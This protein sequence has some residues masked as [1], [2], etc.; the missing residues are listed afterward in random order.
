MEIDIV[1]AGI[2]AQPENLPKMP[3]ERFRNF[4]LLFAMKEVVQLPVNRIL[5]DGLHLRCDG[6][7]QRL[8]HVTIETGYREKPGIA[9]ELELGDRLRVFS[10]VGGNGSVFV[11]LEGDILVLPPRSIDDAS[12]ALSELSGDLHAL[13]IRTAKPLLGEG[14][15]EGRLV[16]GRLREDN[17]LVR[18]PATHRDDATDLEPCI[19]KL[20]L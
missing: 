14:R 4:A 9:R 12:S 7:R 13:Q 2:V 5:G 10:C 15:F 8:R 1:E 20:G 19:A 17:P 6:K 16:V 3:L 11:H 18:K